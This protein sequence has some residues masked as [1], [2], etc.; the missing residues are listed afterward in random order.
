MKMFLYQ[1][2]LL[3]GWLGIT[4]GG[5]AALHAQQ[6][7]VYDQYFYFNSFETDADLVGWESGG[8][9]ESSGLDGGWA[10]KTSNEPHL[11]SPE[12]DLSGVESPVVCFFSTNIPSDNGNG[13]L[14]G[15]FIS[16]DGVNYKQQPRTPA[17]IERM[18]SGYRIAFPVSKKVKRIKIDN[19]SVAAFCIYDAANRGQ[20]SEQLVFNG[21]ET[22]GALE[23]WKTDGTIT[24]YSSWN[25]D[26]GEQY[27]SC[28]SLVSPALNLTDMQEPQLS[29]VTNRSLKVSVSSDGIN[30]QLLSE[31]EASYSGYEKHRFLLPRTT[32]RIKL[33][34]K[35][36]ATTDVDNICICDRTL[37]RTRWEGM[38]DAI[39]HAEVV[40]EAAPGLEWRRDGDSLILEG[41]A[42]GG[43]TAWLTVLPGRP[44]DRGEIRLNF[45]WQNTSPE[46]VSIVAGKTE[47]T[48]GGEALIDFGVDNNNFSVYLNHCV[49]KIPVKSAGPVRVAVSG[50]AYVY[51][52]NNLNYSLKPE[53]WYE[54]IPDNGW[55]EFVNERYGGSLVG[56]NRIVHGRPFSYQAYPYGNYYGPEPSFVNVNNDSVADLFISYNSGDYNSA[57]PYLYIRDEQG[58]LREKSVEAKNN[59]KVFLADINNDGRPDWFMTDGQVY[60]QNADG[61]FLEKKVR[62]MTPSEWENGGRNDSWSSSGGGLIVQDWNDALHVDLIVGSGSGVYHN[63]GNSVQSIDFNGDGRPDLLNSITGQLLL[64]MGNDTYVTV[65]IGGQVYFRDL[66]GD[67][68]LD[69][70]LYDEGT[71]V[72]KA[73]IRESDGT[74]REEVLMEGISLDGQLWCYDLDKDGDVDILLPFSYDVA[75][76]AAYLVVMENDGQGRFT[77]HESYTEEKVLFRACADVDHDGVMDI[78]AQAGTRGYSSYYKKWEETLESPYRVYLFRGNGD[79]TFSLQP[80]PLVTLKNSFGNILVADVNSDGRYELV[81]GD[82][83]VCLQGVTPNQMPEKMA[84]PEF[85]YEAATGYLKIMWEAGRDAETSPA[86]LTYALRIGSA[87]GKGDMFYAHAYA[88]GRRRNLL[89]GNMG[90][91]LSKVLS[92]GGWPEGKYYMSVQAVDPVCGGSPWSEE[93]VFE[94]TG[95]TLAPFSVSRAKTVMDSVTVVY[96]GAYNPEYRYLWDFDGGKVC[97]ASEDSVR[98]MLCYDVPG[99]KT[100]SLKIADAAG[101]VL[102]SSEKSFFVFANKFEIGGVTYDVSASPL[103]FVDLGGNGVI[104]AITDNGVFEGDGQGNFTKVKKIYNTNLT[105]GNVKLVDVTGNGTAE[106]V[107]YSSRYA[108]ETYQTAA[109]Y[110]NAGGMTLTKP[111]SVV[112]MTGCEGTRPGTFFDVDNDGKEDYFIN[113]VL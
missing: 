45:K 50:L 20:I 69:Y 111:S 33:E 102:A 57:T 11:I 77:M 93:A 3:L 17:T 25:Y 24:R 19:Y 30:Y 28:D 23:G 39:A 59:N 106:I 67:G 58:N 88:D 7:V 5:G 29:V 37:V 54:D 86:D 101:N 41:T 63:L 97:A 1:A 85:L 99:E 83:V 96:E 104:D 95:V 61:T 105:F 55:M 9:V 22:A 26:K 79:L 66:N 108:G 44:L 107:E 60:I 36:G 27:L 112:D 47:I 10:V 98:R 100:V 42:S 34:G 91:D 53:C 70:V 113:G 76:A 31:C 84:A 21:F 6:K 65:N 94:K 8:R 81:A 109:I 38:L 35:E 12:F 82:T 52:D 73:V 92:V 46:R 18:E 4:A 13:L 75:N 110:K 32:C 2:L 103:Q 78:V 43:C 51:K 62:L 16:E 80:Q 49:L 90:H 72:V 68:L 87:P 56:L 15:I 71:K 89:D 64:N 40:T 48:A 14:T 74:E